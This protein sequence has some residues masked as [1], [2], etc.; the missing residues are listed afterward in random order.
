MMNALALANIDCYVWHPSRELILYQRGKQPS[1][2]MYRAPQDRYTSAFSDRV[3]AEHQRV[4]GRGL[5]RP[6][7]QM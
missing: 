1:V 4:T 5:T 7:P 6:R 3:M 2:Q